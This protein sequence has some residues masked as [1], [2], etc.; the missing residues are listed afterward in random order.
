MFHVYCFFFFFVFFFIVD[1]LFYFD[2]IISSVL[3]YQEK[4]NLFLVKFF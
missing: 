4:P 3:C 2:S 1:I